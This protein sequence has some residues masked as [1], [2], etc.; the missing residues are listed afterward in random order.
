MSDPEPLPEHVAR[1]R[2]YWDE[3][4]APLLNRATQSQLQP[5]S[6]IKLFVWL[7]ALRAGMTPDDRID[8]RSLDDLNRNSPLKP[9]FFAV[10]LIQ[11]PLR[12]VGRAKLSPRKRPIALPSR[13]RT[14]HSRTSGW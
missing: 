6:T 4:N 1:N 8:N 7:A 13:L 11:A 2:A 10:T 3:I 12:L 14:S 9:V 5:G